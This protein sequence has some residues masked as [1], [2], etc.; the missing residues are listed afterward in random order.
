M[1]TVTQHY[2]NPRTGKGWTDE[3]EA[4]ISEIMETET[5]YVDYGWGRRL[6]SCGRMEAIRQMIRR[7][8]REPGYV[9]PKPTVYRAFPKVCV[10]CGKLFD[11]VGLWRP[12]QAQYCS[13]KCKP[14]QPSRKPQPVLINISASGPVVETKV[15]SEPLRARQLRASTEKRNPLSKGEQ[16]KT[17]EA[18]CRKCIY[19]S[20][21][22]GSLVF[23]NESKPVKLQ[24][25]FDHFEPYA[26][27]KNN[28]KE[29]IFAACQICNSFKSD[30]VFD[31]LVDTRAFL[32][33][34]WES[35]GYSEHFPGAKPFRADKSLCNPN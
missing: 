30:L 3:E 1:E 6:E 17:V 11:A 24:E 12:Q 8:S 16:R 13:K 10:T 35:S 22:F 9:P 28:R 19:C 26:L 31:S 25:R 27:R 14:T 7:K 29:N 20:R 5:A 32:A 34:K 33:R 2:I 15:L 23:D 18:Q 4:I 21:A